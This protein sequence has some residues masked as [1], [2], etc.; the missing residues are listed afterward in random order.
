[1]NQEPTLTEVL[2]SHMFE[3]FISLNKYPETSSFYEFWEEKMCASAQKKEVNKLDSVTNETVSE[4]NNHATYDLTK[5]SV[6]DIEVSDCCDQDEILPKLSAYKILKKAGI[7][8]DYGPDIINKSALRMVRRFFR[9]IFMKDNK[10]LVRRSFVNIE[11]EEVVRDLKTMVTKYFGIEDS[12]PLA[13]FFLRLLSLKPINDPN[14]ESESELNA[15]NFLKALNKFS[16]TR[17]DKV[18]KFPEFRI[19][20][21]YIFT[22]Q[23]PDS[24]TSCID[25]MFEQ[26]HKII[27]SNRDKYFN[28]FS[29]LFQRCQ[30][31]L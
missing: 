25:A 31:L 30:P 13:L 7:K 23:L 8:K 19:L 14:A 10:K 4:S 16:I 24:Q 28:T 6:Q 26:E 22:C 9:R 3:N 15:H 21:N 1:M 27:G 29:K 20:I 5:S 12:E 11:F 2:P 18:H 17:F